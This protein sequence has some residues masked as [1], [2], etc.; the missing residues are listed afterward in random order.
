V[1]GAVRIGTRRKRD[2]ERIDGALRLDPWDGV[3][4][5]LDGQP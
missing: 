4:V 5:W 2:N 3:V 1:H